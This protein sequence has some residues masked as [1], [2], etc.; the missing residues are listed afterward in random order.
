MQTGRGEGRRADE[1]AGGSAHSGLLKEG[2]TLGISLTCKGSVKLH[3]LEFVGNWCCDQMEGWG[4]SVLECFP[5][6][7]SFIK[8]KTGVLSL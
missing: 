5:T 4:P 6:G 7:S 8:L 1:M 2:I 3:W